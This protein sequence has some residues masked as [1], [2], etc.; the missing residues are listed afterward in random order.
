MRFIYTI[1]SRVNDVEDV[2]KVEAPVS[3]VLFSFVIY[4]IDDLLL[5]L[6]S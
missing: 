5:L 1:D 3:D 2:L 4:C 6:S